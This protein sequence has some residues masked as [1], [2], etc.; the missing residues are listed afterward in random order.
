MAAMRLES[1][2][3][4]FR[5]KPTDVELIDHYLRLKINGH[6]NE[7]SV[8]R[9]V[10]VCKVEPWDLPDLSIIRTPDPEWFFFCPRDR[11][12]PNGQRS[13]RATGAGYWKATGKD[14]S[15]VSKKMGG[16]IGTKKTL[17]FYTGRAPKGA[18]TNWVIHEYRPTLKELD[19]TQPGQ[20]AFVLCR[21]FDKSEE[22]K[23]DENDDGSNCDDQDTLAPSPA[24]TKY[25]GEDFPSDPT[26]LQHSPVSAGCTVEKCEGDASDS[27]SSEI[28]VPFQCAS[29]SGIAFDSEAKLQEET[30][31]EVDPQ[32]DEALNHFYDP[33]DP[34]SLSHLDNMV[35]ERDD[36]MGLLFPFAHGDGCSEMPSERAYE[37]DDIS[38][39]LDSVFD[40]PG[41]QLFG[42]A[43][44]DEAFFGENA[45]FTVFDNPGGQL[46]GVAENDE[47]FFGESALTLNS[48]AYGEDA[49]IREKGVYSGDPFAEG[50]HG[51]QGGA[52]VQRFSVGSVDDQH[53]GSCHIIQNP[54]LVDGD[55]FSEASL[56]QF[57][58]L[59]NAIDNA[60]VLYMGNVNE[61]R[62]ADNVIKIRSRAQDQLPFP[63][64]FEEQGTANRRVRL[65]ITPELNRAHESVPAVAG[66]LETSGAGNVIHDAI[67]QSF[68]LKLFPKL[69]GSGQMQRNAPIRSYGFTNRSI[70]CMLMIAIVAVLFMV[71]VAFW[72]L[73]MTPMQ[74]SFMI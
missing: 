48:A 14:R 2:P 47:A 52:F 72:D 51:E 24:A 73:S 23:Q 1:L 3:L 4:G 57:C 39:F 56:E 10:D 34:P 29:N 15:I 41:G 12:Y 31:Y 70:T 62:R 9:E 25:S 27:S 40:N 64:M 5:F 22:K 11:K 68:N 13:N 26:V 59:P 38:E 44:N 45:L 28:I 58:T 55:I 50:S 16:L 7:V 17:V 36:G 18:R 69:I 63:S 61:S 74:A 32:L 35:L 49:F 43:E 66:D 8:I 53:T 54:V 71:F 33:Q 30:V 65:Q 37:T 21:L 60:P 42:V 67:G 6:E 46:F 20:E 19:G